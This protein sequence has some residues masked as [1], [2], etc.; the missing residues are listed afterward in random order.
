MD[1]KEK[2]SEKMSR[3]IDKEATNV[4]TKCYNQ[5]EYLIK[6]GLKKDIEKVAKSL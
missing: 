5:V 6:N 2:I 1:K 3:Q 4:I